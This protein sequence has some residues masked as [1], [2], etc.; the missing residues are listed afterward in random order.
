MN[1]E[2]KPVTRIYI[3]E[4]GN[5]GFVFHPDGLSGLT[6]PHEIRQTHTKAETQKWSEKRKRDGGKKT[7]ISAVVCVLEQVNSLYSRIAITST[8]QQGC[9]WLELNAVWPDQT[10]GLFFSLFVK[11]QI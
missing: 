1:K 4:D 11:M 6:Q 5:Q 9:S 7:W 8:L 2:M 3:H 10:R